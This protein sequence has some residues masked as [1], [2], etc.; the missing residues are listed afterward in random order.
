MKL[1]DAKKIAKHISTNLN[2]TSKGR[3]K[4]EK[5]K[6]CIRRY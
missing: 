2:K 1:K 6:K 4:S 3:F 5:Q